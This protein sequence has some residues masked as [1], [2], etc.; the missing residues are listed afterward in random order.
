LTVN[1]VGKRDATVAIATVLCSQNV[2]GSC[3]C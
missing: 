1:V 2:Q 3:P